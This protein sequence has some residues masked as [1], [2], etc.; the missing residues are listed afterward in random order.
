MIVVQ[1]EFLAGRFHATPWGRNV[2]EGEVEWPPSPYRLARALVD[3]W[4]RRFP[5][6]GEDRVLPLLQVLGGTP[7]F[8]LPP[9]TASHTRVFLSQNKEDSTKKQLVFDGFVILERGARVLMGFDESLEAQERSDLEALLGELNYF[10]RSESWIRASISSV[11]PGHWNCVM[12]DETPAATGHELTRVACLLPR[13]SFKPTPALPRKKKTL[14][15]DDPWLDALSCGT[16][17]LL[18]EGWSD[19]PAISW[20]NFARSRDA[21]SGVPRTTSRAMTSCFRF[22]RYAVSCTVPPRILDTIS[23]A[24]RVRGYLMGIHK[25]IEGDDPT[26]VSRTF[27]GKTVEGKP[28]RGHQHAFFLPEDSDGDGRI[29]HISV[30]ASEP[31]TAS[32]LA[33]IDRLNSIW[34]SKGRPEIDLV[35]TSLLDHPPRVESKT[36][37]SATPFTLSRHHRRGRG[38]LHQWL[39]QELARACRNHGIPTPAGVRWIS[40]THHLAHRYRWLDFLCSRKGKPRQRGYG[41]ILTF[42][43]PVSGPFTLGAGAH[44]GMGQFIPHKE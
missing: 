21:L 36:W 9:A 26:R 40:G 37:V 4:K 30:H 27:S 42:D 2:N 11:E 18:K 10:G 31:F 19:P 12:V 20:L 1:L 25:R 24:E 44:F 14:M 16:A 29:D 28:A 17:R 33:A 23:V 38:T 7:R 6:W 32:E 15:F 39:E 34:Q 41:C 5:D 35:L 13:P 43:E 8:A 3:V 22:A